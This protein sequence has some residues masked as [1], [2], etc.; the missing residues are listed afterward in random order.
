MGLWYSKDIGMSLTAYADADHAGCQDTR[1]ST[2]GSAQFLGDKLVSWSSK[3]Q[4]STAISNS[5]VLLQQK[6]DCSMLQQRSTFKSQAHRCTLPFYKGVGGEWNCGTLLC[7][8]GI[9]T[10]LHLYQTLAKRKIQILDRKARYEKHVSG[11]AKTSDGG[12]GRV[13]LIYMNYLAYELYWNILSRNMNPIATQQVALD[14]AL[15]PPEKRIKI[16]RCNARIAFSKPQREETYQVT[17]EALK[18]SPCYPTFLITAEVPEIYMHQFWNTIT[19]I[20]DTYAYSFK[21]DKKK[22][23][24]DTECN[25]LSAIHTDQM[26]QPWR[27]FAAIINRKTLCMVEPKKARK[28]KKVASPSRKL[29]PVLEA[30]LVKKTKRVKRPAKK[31]TTTPT[32]GVVIRDTPGVF[33]SKKKAPTKGDIGKGMELL[34]DVAL[35][36]AAQ[37]KEAL[38]KS[39]LETHKDGES[40]DEDGNSDA[41]DNERTDSNNDDEN[42]SF[43]L[44]DYDKD[45]HDEDYESND[46][47]ENVYEEEDDDLYKDMD[48]R[49]LGV[50][51]DKE[52]KGDEEMTDADQNQSSS[53]LSD[54]ASKFLILENIPPTVD[55][56]AFMMNVKI[57][58]EESSTQAPS[59]FTV[60]ETAILET[61]TAHTITIPLT[62][63]MITPLPQ[64]TTPSPA[65]TTIPTTTSIPALLDFS[66]LFGFDQR[67]STL[68]T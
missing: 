38:R 59:L 13:K 24:V 57:R 28:F 65:P 18:L 9:S 67:V 43:T 41:D 42:P 48:V 10:G 53:I 31:S 1:S 19:K 3:K 12:I 2:S 63:S 5:S 60:P 23:P 62:I 17:L 34:F 54:F 35:L 22:C 25:M 39:K 40:K 36:E 21:L 45:E 68:E 52:R 11:I 51:H 26:H 56:V 55:E 37:V 30:K 14:N 33:V 4:K 61:A 6:C 7:S 29:S 49:L 66:S 8:D 27:T 64:L 20:R 16:E 47:Y 15:V 58:Q 32:T 50:E 46:D 44:K